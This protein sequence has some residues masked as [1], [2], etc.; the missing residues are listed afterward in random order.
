[1][2]ERVGVAVP[3]LQEGRTKME[4]AFKEPVST[5]TMI[6]W[7]KGKVTGQK[8]PLKPRDVWAIRARLQISN[9]VR[10][11]ALF[12]LAIDSKLRGCDLV[13]L[14]VEDVMQ[15]SQVRYRALM[16]QRKTGA[17]VQF[18]ITDQSRNAL[19]DWVTEKELKSS[20]WL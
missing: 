8:P 2:R 12:N 7:N 3:V 15:G 20:E 14:R 18:E 6:P 19:A 10:D 4:T 17:P 1:M 16:T 11:L 9:R 13:H 5:K